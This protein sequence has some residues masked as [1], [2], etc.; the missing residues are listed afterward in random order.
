MAELVELSLPGSATL[1][2]GPGLMAGVAEP[3]EA[4]ERVVE[5]VAGVVAVGAGV[6]AAAGVLVA[7]G[8]FAS[9]L[10]AIP[11]RGSPPGPVGRE[12]GTPGAAVPAAHQRLRLSPG[13]MP[14]AARWRLAQ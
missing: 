1:L 2:A 12:R 10:G 8:A 13:H 9:A 7:A 11:D 4:V 5:P 6:M 14:V 3:G